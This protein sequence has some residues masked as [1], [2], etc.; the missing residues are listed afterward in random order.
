VL[1]ALDGMLPGCCSSSAP[2]DVSIL[3]VDAGAARIRRLRSSGVHENSTRST[4]TLNVNT[5]AVVMSSAVYALR[6]EPLLVRGSTVNAQDFAMRT[7][8]P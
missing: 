7:Q 6:R 4:G 2:R 5:A 8:W 3:L 1:W